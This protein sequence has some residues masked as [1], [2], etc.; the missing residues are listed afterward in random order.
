M[1]KHDEFIQSLEGELTPEQASQLIDGYEGDTDDKSEEGGAPD[2]STA[3]DDNKPEGE[4]ST[5]EQNDDDKGGEAEKPIEPPEEELNADN[6]VIL[7]KD[8][9]HTISYD[10]LVDAREQAKSERARADAAEA[11]AQAA[12]QELETLRQAAQARADAGESPTAVDRQAAAAEAAIAEGVDPELFGDFSEEDLAKGINNLVNSRVSAQ[13][14]AALAQHLM[15][16][17]QKHE[18]S[19]AEAHYQSIYAAHPD[20]DSIVESKELADWVNAQPSFM[21]QAC[22]AV[23][24]SGS[25]QEVIELFDR[26]K[27]ATGTT[28]EAPARESEEDIKAAAKA[29]VA[30]A[31]TADAPTSLTDIPGGRMGASSRDEAMADMD[32]VGLLENMDDMT[33]EQI[34]TFLNRL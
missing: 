28:Q 29:A 33:P 32:A 7:A 24:D 31:Q 2:A 30:K 17:Q 22:E 23:L 10:K 8:R 4:A 27:Q 11:K 1:T 26:F 5:T 20:A 6:A 19:E 34:E 14:E 13:V 18:Q 9:K 25:A 12:L 21:R 15:P 3:K 16:L